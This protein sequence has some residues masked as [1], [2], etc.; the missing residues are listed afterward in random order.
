M[1]LFLVYCSTIPYPFAEVF[2]RFV[3][4]DV[5]ETSCPGGNGFTV[6]FDN[7]IVNTSIMLLLLAAKILG[8][9]VLHIKLIPTI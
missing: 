9:V 6:R 8:Y 3:E 4:V 2:V 1:I 7:L 5:L